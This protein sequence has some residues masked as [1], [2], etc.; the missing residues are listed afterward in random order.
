MNP[1]NGLTS[2]ESRRQANQHL[3]MKL[4]QKRSSSQTQGEEQQ[5][6]P[7]TDDSK[8]KKRPF[9]DINHGETCINCLNVLH[10]EVLNQSMRQIREQVENMFSTSP[11]TSL[12]S[13][14]SSGLERDMISVQLQFTIPAIF[15]MSRVP[16]RTFVTQHVEKVVNFSTFD[17]ILSQFYSIL[18]P[19]RYGIQVNSDAKLIVAV[20]PMVQDQL[21]MTLI[22]YPEFKFKKPKRKFGGFVN[23]NSTAPSLHVAGRE[24]A[25]QTEGVTVEEED[26]PRMNIG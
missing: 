13:S 11:E 24:D 17:I 12:T 2:E 19:L 14:S 20:K 21:A 3:Q 4:K 8:N 22:V 6:Q 23:H 1:R 15:D 18:L 26:L 25:D 5:E 10:P 16:C 9:I 7:L